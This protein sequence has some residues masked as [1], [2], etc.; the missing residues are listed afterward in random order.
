MKGLSS[1]TSTSSRSASS[2]SFCKSTEHQVSVCPH[3]LPVW[4]ELQKGIIPLS[5]LSDL[6]STSRTV[7][8][9]NPFNWFQQGAEWGNLFKHTEKA[10]TKVL[11]YQE[12]ERLKASGKK[13]SRATKEKTCGYCGSKG[14]TRR[15]CG[16]LSSDKTKLSKANRNFREWVYQD[17]V[18]EK[19]LSTGAIIQFDIASEE[20]YNAPAI[21]K[22]VTTLVTD[23][24]WETM[25]V[26]STMDTPQSGWNYARTCNIGSERLDNIINFFKSYILVK[27]SAKPFTDLGFNMRNG[28]SAIEASSVGTPLPVWTEDRKQRLLGWENQEKLSY[29]APIVSGYKVI[30]RAPQILSEDWVEG[31][32]DEMAVIF[33]KFTRE[34]LDTIG[35]LD[36]IQSWQTSPVS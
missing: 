31:Y 33:R 26:F 27:T 8:R 23:V 20:R 24:N 3:V 34:E 28:Y 14:H 29:N 36:H 5:L 7:G 11:A 32:S 35:V 25:N 15:T 4:R 9:Y 18:Q 2:C 1:K 16:L 19:G 10:A 17:L 6:A 22:K 13:K 30:S 12:R 21:E